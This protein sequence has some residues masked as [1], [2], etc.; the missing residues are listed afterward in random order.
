MSAVTVAA[1]PTR[2]IENMRD[3]FNLKQADRLLPLA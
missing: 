2:S 1:L 3:L